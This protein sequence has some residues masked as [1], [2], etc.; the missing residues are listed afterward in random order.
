MKIPQSASHP[1]ILCVGQVTADFSPDFGTC[2]GTNVFNVDN[3]DC[4]PPCRE[5]ALLFV[6][7][8]P[9]I[10]YVCILNVFCSPPTR[11]DA[12]CVFV[13]SV[14]LL[15]QAVTWK[16][17]QAIRV[18]IQQAQASQDHRWQGAYIGAKITAHFMTISLSNFHFSLRIYAKRKSLFSEWTTSRIMQ[19]NVKIKLRRV[20]CHMR[21]WELRSTQ[22]NEWKGIS[23]HNCCQYESK[24]KRRFWTQRFVLQW[25]FS[26]LLLLFTLHLLFPLLSGHQICGVGVTCMQTRGTKLGLPKSC[27][28]LCNFCIRTV[29][30]QSCNVSGRNG[31]WW[32]HFPSQ[33]GAFRDVLWTAAPPTIKLYNIIG[34][35]ERGP[36]S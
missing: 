16:P 5:L 23:C 33:S 1:K 29:S 24:S 30:N 9:S 26:V 3:R 22:K 12:W 14:S 36:R 18:W 28:S 31:I 34:L 4:K 17:H 32:A 19:A 20:L 27:L 11:G 25:R 15:C 10:L 7:L 35:L 6:C 13:F 8:V 2:R 21:I